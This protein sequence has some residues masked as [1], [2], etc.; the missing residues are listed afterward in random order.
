MSGDRLPDTPCAYCGDE[1][2]TR[3]RCNLEGQHERDYLDELL[4]R[5][6]AAAG[7]AL[8]VEIEADMMDT[9]CDGFFDRLNAEMDSRAEREARR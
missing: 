8:A 9:D 7:R 6:L 5:E 1:T 3:T 4:D 2:H